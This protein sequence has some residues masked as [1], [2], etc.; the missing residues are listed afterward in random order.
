[1]I[2]NMMRKHK[3]LFLGVV[4]VLIVPMFVL[5]GGSYGA[6]QSAP[7]RT[8]EAVAVVGERPIAA[9]DFRSYLQAERQQ[10][11]QFHSM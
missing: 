8:I 11:G 9:D 4:L 3:R 2:Q 5:W 6:G 10:R 1:M 7:E